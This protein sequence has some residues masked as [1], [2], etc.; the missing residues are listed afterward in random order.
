MS[1]G[2]IHESFEGPW[3]AHPQIRNA[4]LAGILTA[5]AFALSRA[6]VISGSVEIGLYALA[7]LVGGYHWTREGIEELVRHR[8][9][10]INILMFVAAI[11]SAVLGL[12]DEAAF[13]VFLYAIAEGLE[14]ST[15]ARTRSS[16]RKLLDLAPREAR[17]LRDGHEITILAEQ[18][19]VGDIFIVKPGESVATD[20][21]ILE[22][23]SSLNEASVT[24]ESIPVDKKEGM[25][26]LAATLNQEGL[27]KIRALAAFEDNTLSKMIHLVEEAQDQ[28]GK[29]QTFI[30]AFGNRYSPMVFLA[31]GL[32]GLVPPLLGLP[33]IEWATRAVILLVAAAPCALVMSTPVGTAAGIS[34][35]GRN[36]VLI[37]GGV[38]LEN[39]GRLRVVALDK[40][41]TL[42]RGEPVVTDII[43]LNG[44]ESRLLDLAYSV[45]SHSEHPLAGAIVRKGEQVGARKLKVAEFSA[46]P[47]YGARAIVEGDIVYV[48]KQSLF[49]KLGLDTRA[50]ANIDA[51]RRQGKT[52]MLVGTDDE[53]HGVIAIKDTPRTSAR[54]VV[55]G[56]QRMGI[57]VVMLT[58]D[59]DLTARAIAGELGI[60]DVRS[61]LKPEAKIRALQ[62]L[63]REY[64]PA[65]M[66]GDGIN[67]APALAGATV[68][69]AMGTAGA[70][71]AIEAADV[72]LIGDDLT[73]VA[74]AIDLGKRS[75]GIGLQ[76]IVFSVLVLAVLIPAALL[77]ALSVAAAVLVH[78]G[79]EIL[80]VANGLRVA[81]N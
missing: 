42:T 39:L 22:G 43:S 25:Q 67:D 79:S 59:N 32:I 1:H 80:A 7:M 23:R 8:R 49:D 35:A 63:Q 5:V 58:G 44:S 48:G 61:D 10:G 81:R 14:E 75:R 45:E 20:G 19:Q 13:L 29:A 55:A 64:G 77:G 9:L 50:G 26:V 33:A 54:E 18:I 15:Y 69:I 17:V 34:K 36:G 40:T 65:A 16:I 78:E 3:Y 21:I 74:F 46:L 6:L 12:W 37:K 73:K 27:L 76:N 31:A 62:D 28:K 53:V 24:G 68:G 52:I 66:V 47:G 57:K 70:D 60:D 41:G 72:A 51:L 71:A 56:L 38:H 2:D 30:E 4:I 11:G